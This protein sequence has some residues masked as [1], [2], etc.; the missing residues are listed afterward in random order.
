M[1]GDRSPLD[2]RYLIS[3]RTSVVMFGFLRQ[4]NLRGL[5]GIR[6]RRALL[7]LVRGSIIN[8]AFILGSFVLSQFFDKSMPV[9]Y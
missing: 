7:R 2:R 4:P 6:T 8:A 9:I 3:S 1:V 5:I